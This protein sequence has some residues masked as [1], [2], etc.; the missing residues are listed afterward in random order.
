M[1]EACGAA[2]QAAKAAFERAD[3]LRRE[4]WGAD[5]ACKGLQ[6]SIRELRDAGEGWA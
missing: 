3:A 1:S 2:G 4:I 5:E 6:A